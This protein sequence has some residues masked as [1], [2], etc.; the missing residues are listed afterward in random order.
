MSS[1]EILAKAKEYKEVIQFIKQLEAE[2][3]TLK[4]AIVAEMEARE[5][6]TIETDLFTIKY[7]EYKNTRF[8]SKSFKATHAELYEQYIKTT[9]A[10]RFQVA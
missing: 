9:A 3:E 4:V 1:T 6:D 10:R 8:D 7:I 5:K 2:A